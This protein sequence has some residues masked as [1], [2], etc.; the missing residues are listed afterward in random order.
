LANPFSDIIEFLK[1]GKME[2]E[3][4]REM[5]KVVSKKEEIGNVI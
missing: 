4:E 3:D 2:K 5:E 1:S